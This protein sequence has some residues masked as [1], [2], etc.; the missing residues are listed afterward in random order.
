[1]LMDSWKVPWLE[2]LSPKKHSV[3]SSVPLILEAMPEPVAMGMPAP[4]MPLAPRMPRDT[5]A[6][7]MEP[8][9]PRQ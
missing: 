6:A 4:T 3:T 5:S 1:M 2:A 8:P 7:C 9:L